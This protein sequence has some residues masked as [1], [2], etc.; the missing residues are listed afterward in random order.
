MVPPGAYVPKPSAAHLT[1]EFWDG[2]S[3]PKWNERKGSLTSLKEVRL[4]VDGLLT[5]VKDSMQRC[6]LW[7][8]CCLHPSGFAMSACATQAASYPRLAN[9][10][11]YDVNQAL[12]KIIT[13]DSHQQVAA[14]LHAIA[15]G[16]MAG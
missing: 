11:W 8:L 4:H 2:L 9:G 6:T 12:K 10:D 13:K 1:Q 16:L 15:V 3:S 14:L 7:V 5:V